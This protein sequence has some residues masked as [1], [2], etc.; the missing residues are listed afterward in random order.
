MKLAPGSLLYPWRQFYSL[1]QNVVKQNI[2]F[3]MV[4]LKTWKN[5][6]FK[7]KWPASV[8]VS[9]ER[10]KIR[11]LEDKKEHTDIMLDTFLPWENLKCILRISII[12]WQ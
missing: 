6:F 2:I 12:V 7:V 9:L 10:P 4:Y 11:N 5:I 3:M 8:N 1:M